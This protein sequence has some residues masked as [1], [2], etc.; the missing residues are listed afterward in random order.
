MTFVATPASG[1]APNITP[2]RIEFTAPSNNGG[3]IKD[4]TRIVINGILNGTYTITE[5]I[6]TGSGYVLT[7]M[8]DSVTE[9]VSNGAFSVT[10]ND[11]DR[12][13]VM[14]NTRN[15]V[16]PTGYT[17]RVLPFAMM[18]ACGLFLIPVTLSG[19]RRKKEEN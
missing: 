13:V 9:Q 17:A 16:S 12:S 5:T 15:A 18:L 7:A 1:T 2:G 3:P 4:N 19:K 8:I 14:T 11:A 6:P 10:V